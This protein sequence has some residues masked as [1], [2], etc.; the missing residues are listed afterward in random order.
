MFC[1]TVFAQYHRSNGHSDCVCVGVC[2]QRSDP[3]CILQPSISQLIVPSDISVRLQPGPHALA[4]LPLWHQ[5]RSLLAA[6]RDHHLDGDCDRHQFAGHDV[7]HLR[8]GAGQAITDDD[9]RSCLPVH[10]CRRPV[11]CLP[12]A[13]LRDCQLSRGEWDRQ[14]GHCF[15]Q[16]QRRPAQQSVYIWPKHNHYL[17]GI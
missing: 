12:M 15:V 13:S 6:I 3:I 8:H 2:W 17:H 1:K 7:L 9:M 4:A 10:I 11:G 5:Q 14:R 16:L